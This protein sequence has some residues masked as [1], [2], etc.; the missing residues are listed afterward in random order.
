M[1][2]NWQDI[3]KT[4]APVLG[5]ALRGPLAGMA[6]KKIADVL[7]LPEGTEEAVAAAIRGATPEDMLKLKQADQQFARDMRALDVDLERVYA[8]D[9]DSARKMASETQAK[10]PAVL[11][12]LIVAA[13][14][15]LE[16]Y[17]LLK[18]IPKEV[19]EM[20]A[21]RILGTLDAAFITVLSFWLGTSA[22]SAMKDATISKLASA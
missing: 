5:T 4:V 17:V 15:G 13:A 7:S 10:T 1:N 9:R 18:G 6:V 20:V 16:G 19:S 14:L 22:R 12:W 2:F 8:G 11:S 3:I 21:G